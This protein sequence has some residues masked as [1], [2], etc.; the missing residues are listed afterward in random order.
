[1]DYIFLVQAI[2]LIAFFATYYTKEELAQK[3]FLAFVLSLGIGIVFT[4]YSIVT[5]GG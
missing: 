2:L 5:M 3:I 4:I 1:M